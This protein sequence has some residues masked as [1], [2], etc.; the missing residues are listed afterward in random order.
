MIKNSAICGTIFSILVSIGISFVNINVAYS[1]LFSS[2]L[3]IINMVGL[4]FIWKYVSGYNSPKMGVFI[5]IMKYPLM[6]FAIFWAS[7]QSWV[8]S[9]GIAIGVCEFLIII[10]LTVLLKNAKKNNFL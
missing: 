7:K 5:G 6:G 8:N 1:A 4:A 10:V 2:L 3:L 9:I